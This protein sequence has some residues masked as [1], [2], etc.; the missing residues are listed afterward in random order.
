MA[1]FDLQAIIDS[2]GPDSGPA[3]A[4][5]LNPRFHDLLRLVGFEKRFVRGEGPYLFDEEGNRYLDAIGGFASLSLGRD[6]PV[7]RDALEQALRIAPPAL[8]Q[9]ETPPLAVALAESLKRF[10]DR[11]HDRVFFVN[12]GAESVE[13]AMKIARAATGRPGF[14]YWSNA[15][16]GLTLGALSLNGADWLRRGFEPLIPGCRE[17]PFCDLDRLRDA[18]AD[19]SVAAFFFEPIQGKGVIPHPPGVLKEVAEIC[20]DTGTLLVAD[21][22]QTGLGRA[23]A[24]LASRVD[25]VEADIVCLSKGLSAGSVPVGAILGRAPIF[26]RVFDSVER[27]VVHSSTFRENPLAMT[28]GLAVLHVL[29]EERLVERAAETGD[30]LIRGLRRVAAEVPGIREV[31]G[32]GLMIGVEI[33]PSAISIDMPGLARRTPTL[34]AQALVMR[35]LTEHRLLTQ[36]TSKGSG[37]IK[38]VPPLLISNEDVDWI[39]EAFRSSLIEIGRGRGAA[40]RGLFGML[41]RAPG[42]VIRE[43]LL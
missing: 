28:T 20:R 27:S 4:R 2:F 26:D 40:V 3:Y 36:S 24:A 17:V 42:V 12:S 1:S 41:Q 8:V 43:S 15:F 23:G 6:H 22:V 37:V 21:E 10:V 13:A 25:G 18:L 33:D 29:R 31:R 30:A 19:E 38:V 9:F 34:V 5:H 39:V 7:V 11:P 32:R 14:A 35:L 16:H